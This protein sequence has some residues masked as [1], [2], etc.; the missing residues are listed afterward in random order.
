MPFANHFKMLY[1]L[2]HEVGM[3]HVC[4]LS[5]LHK[6]IESSGAR[7]VVTLLGVEDY[8]PL[9]SHISSDAYL[10][11]HVHDI[12]ESLPGQTPPDAEHVEK[13][14][15]FVRRWD[16]ITP[17]VIHCY[18]GI[19]RSTAAAYTTVCALNPQ[20]PETAIARALRQASPTALPNARIVR[21]ADKIL[22]REGRMVEAVRTMGVHVPALEAEP[23]VLD[24]D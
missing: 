21:L 16:R 9:P 12:T 5:N 20:R 4:S 15:D 22:G 6:T 23:F 10:R 18:A 2:L 7:H 17:L 3:I 1:E 13:L 8:V 11:L 24:I 14:I 19:S